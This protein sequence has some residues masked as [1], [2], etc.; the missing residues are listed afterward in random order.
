MFFEAV[1]G[2]KINLFKSQL[3]GI[4]VGQGVMHKLADLLGCKVGFL[5]TYYLWVPWCLGSAKQKMFN[6]EVK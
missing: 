5:C 2:L 6:F 1:L 4:E 3:I